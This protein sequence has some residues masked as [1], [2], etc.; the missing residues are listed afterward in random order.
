MASCV[1]TIYQ[2]DYKSN[3]LQSAVRQA[4]E[5]WT[6]RIACKNGSQTAFRSQTSKPG[7]IKELSKR[8]SEDQVNMRSCGMVGKETRGV[9]LLSGLK[10]FL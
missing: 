6:Q 2:S 7:P 3:P 5:C 1:F 8:C 9:L 4:S 10:P